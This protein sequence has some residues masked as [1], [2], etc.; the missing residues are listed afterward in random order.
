MQVSTLHEQLK[1]HLLRRMKRDVLKQLPPKREQIV[2][3]ELS[4][5]Q[6]E[7]YR[8]ILTK[9]FK[10]LAGALL[11]KFLFW[12]NPSPELRGRHCT[13]SSTVCCWE[14]FE[15]KRKLQNCLWWLAL[16]SGVKI[17]SSHTMRRKIATSRVEF[18]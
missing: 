5:L 14:G 16:E 18:G 12:T 4:P 10:D 6:K 15:V 8:A 3:V 1:P 9:N 13:W 11:C 2:R 17:L 7:Y